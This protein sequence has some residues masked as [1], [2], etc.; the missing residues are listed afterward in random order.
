MKPIKSFAL[1]ASWCLRISIL[2]FMLVMYWDEFK[3]ID[4]QHLTLNTLLAF[5]YCLF[6]ILLFIGGFQKNA[7]LT[8]ISAIIVFLISIYLLFTA[9]KGTVLDI[10]FLIYVFPFSIGLYFVSNGNN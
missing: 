10:Y 6:G 2:L 5:V 4:F 7:S 3:N 8:V 1:I 9:Y